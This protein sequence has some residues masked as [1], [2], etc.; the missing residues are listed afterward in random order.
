M[1]AGAWREHC[2][3]VEESIDLPSRELVVSEHMEMMADQAELFPVLGAIPQTRKRSPLREMLDAMERHGPL[4]PRA[5]LPMALDLSRQ[6]VADLVND[7]RIATIQVAGREM[8]PVAALEAFLSLERKTGRPVKELTLRESIR[9][10][11]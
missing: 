9:K 3:A 6:R 8:V 11:L 2:A 1:A 7:G 10:N 4:F 5:F